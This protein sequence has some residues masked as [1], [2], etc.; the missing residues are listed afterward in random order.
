[1]RFGNHPKKKKLARQAVKNLRKYA[2][3]VIAQLR[4]HLPKDIL[5]SS[6]IRFERYAKILSQGRKDSHK[7]YSLHEPMFTA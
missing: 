5:E 4:N 2:R 7:I 1:M 6:K 3:K